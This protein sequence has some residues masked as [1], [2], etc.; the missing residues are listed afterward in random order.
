MYSGLTPK[1]LGICVE[2]LSAIAM[3]DYI[4]FDRYQNEDSKDSDLEL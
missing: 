1:I 4:K 3:S 2:H